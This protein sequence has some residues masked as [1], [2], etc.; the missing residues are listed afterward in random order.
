MVELDSGNYGAAG[1]KV[2]E[3]WCEGEVGGKD[4]KADDE[5]LVCSDMEM[6][7]A[8]VLMKMDI[9]GEDEKM[10]VNLQFN[11]EMDKE[12]NEP[13]VELEKEAM[14]A[15]KEQSLELEKYEAESGTK[16]KS[17][18]RRVFERFP[19][20]KSF[21]SE[22][23]N[24]SKESLMTEETSKPDIID[25]GLPSYSEATKDEEDKKENNDE[26]ALTETAKEDITNESQSLNNEPDLKEAS[27]SEVV[28]ESTSEHDHADI[29]EN[30]SQQPAILDDE[31]KQSEEPK[32]PG[33]KSR[34]RFSMF[35][36]EK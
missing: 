35:S 9:N 34:F 26:C 12:N 27:T 31:T 13:D 8:E 11:N 30:E 32:P 18:M 5:A 10:Q 21:G 20:L 4:S 28:T 2:S 36:N 14:M 15:I 33:K 3:G 23:P 1:N 16:P 29:K 6:E 7:K 17:G 24:M 19:F 22:S 25:S